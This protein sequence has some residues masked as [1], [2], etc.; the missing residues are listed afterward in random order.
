[1]ESPEK[2]GTNRFPV[3]KTTALA[4]LKSFSGAVSPRRQSTNVV[5]PPPSWEIDKLVIDSKNGWDATTFEPPSKTPE[6]EE[7]MTKLAETV[8]STEVPA[9][10]EP[11]DT[12]SLTFAQRIRDMIESLPLPAA[13]TPAFTPSRQPSTTGHSEHLEPPGVQ[14]DVLR[15]EDGSAGPPVPPGV[16]QDLVLMLSSEE[17]MNGTEGEGD[18]QRGQRQSIW[19]IL[20]S[21]QWKGKGKQKEQ[22]PEKEQDS[23][24]ASLSSAPSLTREGLMMY[25][26]LE[27]SNDSKVELAEVRSLSDTYV[28]PGSPAPEQP[29][30]DAEWVPSTTNISVYATW[31]GYRLY[32]PP[33][34]MA[35]LDSVSLKATAQAAM[36]TGALKWLLNQ[37][38][39]ILVPVQFK[40]A[41]TLM[42]RLS[43][44]V[45]YI[46]VF[47]AWSWGR[48]KR[49]D[50]GNGVVLTAT[51]LLP[52]A[53]IPLAWDAG[54]I[55]GPILLPKPEDRVPPPN[56]ENSK[57]QQKEKRKRFWLL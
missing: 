8:V 35:T 33:S 49:H 39:D 9:N 28:V 52:V 19:N 1:M 4:R 27:P 25:S 56:L 51:W 55:Y 21:M 36:L 12:G 32:L 44:V 26:P 16:D 43:P 45:G 7:T 54:E 50:K 13:F 48:I 11:E 23:D 34:A 46:G 5:F 20:S 47:V 24:Q 31:W 22:G 17:I 41:L 2:T 57:E 53:L 29:G 38:P 15:A 14:P 6:E 3:A 30:E 10:L 42:R 18:E 37:V 40:A